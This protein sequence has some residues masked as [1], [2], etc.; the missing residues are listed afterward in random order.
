MTCPYPYIRINDIIESDLGDLKKLIDLQMKHM[1]QDAKDIKGSGY[2]ETN[3]ARCGQVKNLSLG[4]IDL[5]IDT[6]NI[7]DYC[8]NPKRLEKYASLYNI[9]P[10]GADDGIWFY[11]SDEAVCGIDCSK[12]EFCFTGIPEGRYAAVT[13]DN[14]MTF[15]LCRTWNYICKWTKEN[16]ESINEIETDEVK[17][18]CFVKFYREYDKEYMT[19]YVPMENR[20]KG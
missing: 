2:V 14:P 6:F 20:V 5:G 18:T 3:R 1:T 16:Q 12:R 15:S 8:V 17:T 11:Q 7:S 4:Q 10:M 9:V 13:V 19:V